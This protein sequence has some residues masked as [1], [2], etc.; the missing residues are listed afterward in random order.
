MSYIRRHPRGVLLKIFVQPRSSKNEI[1]GLY[2]DAIK[3][4]LTAPPVDGAANR[5]CVEFLA[6]CLGLPKSSLEIIS[7]QASRSKLLLYRTKSD[8]SQ[9][10]LNTLKDRIESLM[11]ANKRLD[12]L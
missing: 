2:G 12:R 11:K 3:I 4:R 10:D 7:G 6:K 5:M 9:K 8:D 1:K